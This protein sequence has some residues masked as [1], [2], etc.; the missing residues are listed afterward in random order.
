MLNLAGFNSRLYSFNN[1]TWV[2]LTPS[3]VSQYYRLALTEVNE[4]DLPADPCNNDPDN[5]FHACIRKNISG[6]VSF[7]EKSVFTQTNVQVGCRTTWDSWS[8]KN[9]PVCSRST[10]YRSHVSS[11]KFAVD[12]LIDVKESLEPCLPRTNT[13]SFS[14]CWKLKV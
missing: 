10:Q 11:L 6:Q 14:L 12:L 1:K 7:Q 9:Q 2:S 3:S 5:R 13:Y 4:L 8:D